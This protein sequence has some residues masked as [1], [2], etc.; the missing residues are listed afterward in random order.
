MPDTITVKVRDCACPGGPHP[1]GDTVDILPTL[2]LEGGLEAEGLLADAIAAHPLAE[3]AS[4]AEADRV[5]V[6][7]TRYLR[8]KWLR[9]FVVHGAVG[10]NLL[11]VN[12]RP[13]PFNAEAIL[14]DYALA[15]EV[16]DA[17]DSL[18]S[19]AVLRP[20]LNRPDAPS[21]HGPTV[22]TTPAAT[23]PTP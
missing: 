13:V 3:R 15:K 23:E 7:R 9:A 6:A 4:E 19:A 21:P 12:G 20:F 18:Y 16:A 10:W 8:P 11:D 2:S 5:A 17:C 22:D 14:A 1:F